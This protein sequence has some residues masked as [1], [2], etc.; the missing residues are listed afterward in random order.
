MVSLSASATFVAHCSSSSILKIPNMAFQNTLK[1]AHDKVFECLRSEFALLCCLSSLN[2]WVKM[3]N[4]RSDAMD[5]THG[6]QQHKLLL[7]LLRNH[8]KLI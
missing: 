1:G 5:Y 7:V 8:A 3:Q 6:N 2:S 4:P